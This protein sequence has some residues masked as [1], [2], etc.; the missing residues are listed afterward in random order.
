M[1]LG[2]DPVKDR[3]AWLQ[4]HTA[5]ITGTNAATILEKNRFSNRRYLYW[6]LR[7]LIELEPSN[8]ARL[9]YFLD[10]EPTIDLRFRRLT[11][12]ETRRQRAR[13]HDEH[14]FIGC[15][16]DYQI[17][18]DKRGP[19]IAEY[20]TASPEGYREVVLGGPYESN[21]I[22]LAHNIG[23]W[24]YSWGYLAYMN[25]ESGEITYFD[26]EHDPDFWRLLLAAEVSFMEDVRA[27]REPAP[28]PQITI[29]KASG[30][31]V[32]FED[33]ELSG[34][35]MLREGAMISKAEAVAVAKGAN[36]RVGEIMRRNGSQATEQF[37][38]RVYHKQRQKSTFDQ[39][40]LA[41]KHPEIDQAEF[42]KRGDP[43]WEVR[44]YDRRGK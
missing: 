35:L 9:E 29:P 7:N 34:A 28:A 21:L 5:K 14:D 8:R 30:E 12:R 41:L 2:P 36:E 10:L 16:I 33:E 4:W 32:D 38:W 31:F 42:T 22:Q 17:I 26:I 11:G 25:R 27:E 13:Q 15:T 23:V 37:G 1:I 39:K 24:G 18:K 3:E 44:A 6:E 19:G 43:Y 40:L 20:K